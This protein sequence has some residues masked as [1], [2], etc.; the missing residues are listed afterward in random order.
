MR[1]RD[2][3]AAALIAVAV[4]R[5]HAQQTGK[6][7]RVA[8]V[9]ASFPVAGAIREQSKR[10]TLSWELFEELRRLGYVEG[11]NFVTERSSGEGRTE[12]FAELALSVVRTNPDLIFTDSTGSMLAFKAATTT[13]SIVG[14]SGDPV[15]NG[16]VS[17]LA[18]PGGNITGVSVDVGPDVSGKRLELLKQAVPRVSRV[19][20]VALRGW[21]K[22]PAGIALHQAA[23]KLGVTLVGEPLA[24][25]EEA[26]YR[27]VFATIAQERA[28]ALIVGQQFENRTN[29]RLV[30]ELAEK[31]RLP[32]IFGNRDDAAFGG[33]MT[34]TPD[35]VDLTRHVANDI[36]QILGG[37]N[38]GDIPYYQPR[39]FSL[40]INM[41]TAK[42]LGIEMPPSLLAQADEVIE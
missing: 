8:M 21:E 12:N 4:R 35:L 2:L 15:A 40:T 41:K 26:E 24:V 9:Y 34:Y 19:G 10:G 28:E 36:G 29:Q 38:P 30:I 1:R 7:F 5:A 42:T 23:E 22:T 25:S 18:R 37:T 20:L 6:V 13:I 31:A 17:N 32:A 3:I 14:F 11:Q 33:L 27:R 39:K 16:I